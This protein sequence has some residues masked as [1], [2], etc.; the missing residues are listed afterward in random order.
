LRTERRN[1]IPEPCLESS[2]RRFGARDLI[3]RQ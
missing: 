2:D 1:L 3:A